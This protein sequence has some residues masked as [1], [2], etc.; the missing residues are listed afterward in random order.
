MDAEDGPGAPL[1]C[2]RRLGDDLEGT[3]E[4]GAKVLA[5]VNFTVEVPGG[6]VDDEQVGAAKMGEVLDGVDAAVVVG[7]EMQ[8]IVQ[9]W[10]VG[11]EHTRTWCARGEKPPS[12]LQSLAIGQHSR[13]LSTGTC[14]EPQTAGFYG[15][16]LT[17]CDSLAKCFYSSIDYLELVEP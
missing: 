9:D 12:W 15:T 14:C 5:G 2:V 17:S 13:S 10:R 6:F 1:E 4:D 8:V 3:F 7:V 16:P 11:L